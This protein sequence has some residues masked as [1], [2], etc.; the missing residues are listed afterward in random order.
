[1]LYL[2]ELFLQNV[3]LEDDVVVGHL[4]LLL[5]F[6]DFYLHQ[7][8]LLELRL[9]IKRELRN[10]KLKPL[11]FFVVYVLETYGKALGKGFWLRK[12]ELS[13]L[14]WKKELLQ[15][16][17]SQLEGQEFHIQFD[18]FDLGL[19]DGELL[20]EAFLGEVDDLLI[21]R[22]RLFDVGLEFHY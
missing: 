12:Q 7:H 20:L 1:M 22:E 13:R 15:R 19:V 11:R 10:T 4:N 2:R 6:L 9:L 16:R 5:D 3:D 18:V 8:W 21:A 17:G 14:V